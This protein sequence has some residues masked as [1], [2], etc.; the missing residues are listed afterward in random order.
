MNEPTK[1]EII[2]K[3]NNINYNI[4]ATNKTHIKLKNGR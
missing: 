2:Y 4:V 3:N 1:Y